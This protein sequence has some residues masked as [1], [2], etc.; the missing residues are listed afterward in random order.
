VSS[1]IF[2]VL[3]LCFFHFFFSL[4]VGYKGRKNYA[5]YSLDL[6]CGSLGLEIF[7]VCDLVSLYTYQTQSMLFF[8]FKN[9][10]YFCFSFQNSKI[11]FNAF[12]PFFLL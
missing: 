11:F 8:Y 4:I 5:L 1:V 9:H 6:N 12:F 2:V 7:F 3:E 10:D